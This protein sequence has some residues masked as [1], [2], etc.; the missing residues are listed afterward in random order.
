MSLIRNKTRW[1]IYLFV[2]AL[3]AAWFTKCHAS[4]ANSGATVSVGAAMLRGTA[5]VIDL[6]W[7][8]GASPQSA[9]AWWET[10]L[11]LIGSSAYNG[12]EQPNNFGPSVRYMDGFGRLDIGLGLTYLQNTDVYN[13][14]KMNFSLLLGTHWRGWR[15]KYQH[16]SNAGSQAPNLG[17]DL[18][19]LGRDI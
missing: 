3:M 1:V 16:I 2:V 18:L 7:R 4:E 10:G 14:S 17:R 8:W 11:T 5:P 6:T 19:L 12:A 15:V 9:D 13:G